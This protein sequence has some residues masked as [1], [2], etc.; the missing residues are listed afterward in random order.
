M[1]KTSPDKRIEIL[2][3]ILAFRDIHSMTPTLREI[4]EGVGMDHVNSVTYHLECMQKAGWI[5]RKPGSSR[6]FVSAQGKEA[7]G[8][9]LAPADSE[10]AAVAKLHKVTAAIAAYRSIRREYE[11]LQLDEFARV[12]RRRVM[13]SMTEARN[14]MFAMLGSEGKV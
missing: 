1:S 2:R 7:A 9:T 8:V 14:K 13:Q 4:G 6:I 12:E 11:S 5:E 3:F 10:K